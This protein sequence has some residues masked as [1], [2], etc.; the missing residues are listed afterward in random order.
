MQKEMAS[1]WR[2]RSAW[3]EPTQRSERYAF[4][5]SVSSLSF[6]RLSPESGLDS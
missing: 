2:L 6:V 4:S 1:D 5:I 3:M